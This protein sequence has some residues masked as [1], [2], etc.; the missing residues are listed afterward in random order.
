METDT[1]PR[2]W[3]G[4]ARFERPLAIQ[5]GRRDWLA[6]DAVR[7]Q[8]NS[9][10]TGKIQGISRTL[11][12]GLDCMRSIAQQLPMLAPKFPTHWNREFINRFQGK[13]A[14]EQGTYRKV[15]LMDKRMKPTAGLQ[16]VINRLAERWATASASPPNCTLG[17][18]PRR[19]RKGRCSACKWP[20]EFEIDHAV[21]QLTESS[22]FKPVGACP[23]RIV[24][25]HL[26]AGTLFAPEAFRARRAGPFLVDPVVEVKGALKRLNTVVYATGLSREDIETISND[27][28]RWKALRAIVAA[29]RALKSAL[30]VFQPQIPVKSSRR[31][32]GRIGVL[33]NQAVARAMAGAWRQLT[34]RLP[35][36]NNSKFHGLL[37]AAIATTSEHP[38]EEP[39]LES[40]TEIAVERIRKDDATR[41]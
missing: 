20:E 33:H 31:V 4:T 22:S 2:V 8:S 39:N 12:S 34:G 37:L 17:C 26:L 3:R 11:V 28:D 5:S 40:A 30:A 21:T 25:S 6:D 16:Q 24:A 10:I 27:G 32:R 18:E 7:W 13:S 23:Y 35:A 19:R 36:K 14:D 1:G 38:G 15:P 9:L 41:R 29:E